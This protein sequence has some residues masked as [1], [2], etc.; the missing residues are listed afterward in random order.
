[1]DYIAYAYRMDFDYSIGTLFWGKEEILRER[2]FQWHESDKYSHPLLSCRESPL[3]DYMSP[4]PMLVGTSRTRGHGLI[5]VKDIG[6]ERK[7]TYFGTIISTGDIYISDIKE[8]NYCEDA[9]WTVWKNNYKSRLNEEEMIQL[10]DFM[11]CA[12]QLLGR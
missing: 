8:G 12:R 9:E 3:Q 1:M 10:L 4:I 5:V 7:N 2:F 11:K 6:P